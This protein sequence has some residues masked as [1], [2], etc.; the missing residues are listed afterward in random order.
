MESDIGP[1]ACDSCS[2]QLGVAD[3]GVGTNRFGLNYGNQVTLPTWRSALTAGS[4]R[5]IAAVAS[6]TFIA[7]KA[8]SDRGENLY[9]WIFLV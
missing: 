5:R 8:G 6:A 7:P 9:I 4:D 3:L 1:A 2:S